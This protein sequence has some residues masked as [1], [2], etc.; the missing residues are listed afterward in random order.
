MWG[1]CGVNENDRKKI[2]VYQ[3]SSAV[4]LL[5]VHT[6]GPLAEDSRVARCEKLQSSDRLSNASRDALF[7]VFFRVEVGDQ[8]LGREHQT[9]DAGGVG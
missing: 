7:V 5:S 8:C 9:G 2:S 4:Q 3:R 1:E 6:T